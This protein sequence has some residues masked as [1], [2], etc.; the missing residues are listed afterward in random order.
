MK[1][2]EE[3]LAEMQNTKVAAEDILKIRLENKS[4]RLEKELAEKKQLLVKNP[5]C[6]A[7]T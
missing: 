6:L 2:V 5:R 3:S 4:Q 7:L 1:Q